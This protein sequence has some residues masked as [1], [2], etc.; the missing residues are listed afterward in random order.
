MNE[1]PNLLFIKQLSDGD[2][3]FEEKLLGVIKK[4]L[5]LEIETY[6]GCYNTKQWVKSASI[7]HKIK[8][9]ISILGLTQCHGFAESYENELLEEKGGKHEGFMKILELMITFLNNKE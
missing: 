5:P 7:V 4:E 9:K 6:L 2:A 8:H 3:A 1:E